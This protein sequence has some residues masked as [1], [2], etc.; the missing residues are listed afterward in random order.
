MNIA[1]VSRGFLN[2]LKLGAFF[3]LLWLKALGETQPYIGLLST[4][5]PPRAER[6]LH[7]QRSAWSRSIETMGRRPF[8]DLPAR[9]D[10]TLGAILRDSPGKAHYV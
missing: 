5:P 4:R 9:G 3:Q 2:A 6:E 8:R 7:L 1:F 10:R